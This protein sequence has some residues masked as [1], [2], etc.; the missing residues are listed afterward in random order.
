MSD[1]V[2]SVWAQGK[3]LLTDECILSDELLTLLNIG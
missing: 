2:D 1:N 3:I